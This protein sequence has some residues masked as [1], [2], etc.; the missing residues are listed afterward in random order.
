MVGRWGM[1]E[2]IGPIQVLPEEGDPRAIGVSE[3][4]LDAVADEVRTLVDECY[5]R[6]RAL[7]LEHRRQLDSLAERLLKDETLD[8]QQIYE[9]AGI[10]RP[11][12]AQGAEPGRGQPTPDSTE[13]VAGTAGVEHA[14]ADAGHR[15]PETRT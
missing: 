6:A 4:T 10:Q 15:Q 11:P 12:A 2:R 9:A 8:E 5:Q 14:R 3:G 1:S 13:L 7:L